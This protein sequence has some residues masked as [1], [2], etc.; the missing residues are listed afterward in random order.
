M[1]DEDFIVSMESGTPDHLLPKDFWDILVHR[2]FPVLS[3]TY[4][5]TVVAIALNSGHFI[6]YMFQDKQAYMAAFFVAMWVSVPAILWV[7]MRGSVMMAHKADNWYK[8]TASIMSVTVLFS[9]VLLPEVMIHGQD[10]RTYFVATIP[11]FILMYVFFVKGGL[12]REA[13]HMLSAIGITFLF[14]GAVINFL[15]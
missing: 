4:A 15:Y 9:L 14:Y 7:L 3:L 13:A 8:I 5:T 12:P 1:D 11:V 2:Y 10:L 6:Y